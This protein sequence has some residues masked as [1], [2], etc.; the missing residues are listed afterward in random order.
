MFAQAARSLRRPRGRARSR[1]ASLVPWSI[2]LQP[3][4]ILQHRKGGSILD[5]DRGR[6]ASPGMLLNNSP[7]VI[8]VATPNR[9]GV[10]D[11]GK[12][13]HASAARGGVGC[14]PALPVVESIGQGAGP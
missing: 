11:G 3:S 14:D 8:G 13:Q 12:N 6:I 1:L 4:F 2:P 10:A 9:I 7:P 5:A